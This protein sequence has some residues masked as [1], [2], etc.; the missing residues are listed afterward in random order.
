MIG[1]LFDVTILGANLSGLLSGALLVKRGF[2]VLVVDLESER[3]EIKKSGYTLKK[4]PSLFLGFGQNQIFT[5]IFGE[6]GIPVLEKKR[7]SLAE[8]PYQIVMPQ[9]RID[10]FQ[11]REEL[12]GVLEK[13]F[14][15]QA[16]TMMTFYN[17]IDR[18]STA[19]KNFLS[20]DVV[21]PPSTIRE[22]MRSRHAVKNVFSSFKDKAPSNYRM[23]LDTF[24]MSRPARAFI[25]AQ[26]QFLAQVFPDEM[27]LF[28]A[29]YILGWT[30]K[31]VFKADGGIKAL[32]DICKERISSYRGSFHH[33]TGVEEIAFDKIIGIKFPEVREMVK[34]KYILYTG[35]PEEFF[36][37]HAPK[38][39]KGK[40]KDAMS[41]EEPSAHT[42]TLYLGIDENVVP[43]GMEE[44]VILIRDPEE[45][46]IDANMLFLRLS[47]IGDTGFAPQ[48]KRLLSCTMKVC[49]EADEISVVD[50]QRLSKDA[51]SLIE[52]LIPFLNRFLDFVAMEESFALYQAERREKFRPSIDPDDKFGVAFLPNRTPQKQVF[53]TGPGVLPGL[54]IEG[55]GL[56][57]LQV[58]NLLSKNLIKG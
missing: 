45:E 28:Y 37:T 5:E 9:N 18:Y 43:V 38:Y 49:P 34:T 14:P 41:I 48:G 46:L 22:G 24:Q 15:D 55:E 3:H 56:A 51:L 13:E 44:N 10:V 52:D 42:F 20:Q 27:S 39:Y 8:P 1:K 16:S 54:G 7:F 32:T 40:L 23:F 31:G 50:A 47:S 17:E 4:F 21:Y 11:G 2:N 35:N 26:T 6:L 58:S 12:F 57:A 30:N 29:S 25:D 53:Y 36:K 19:I 33:S